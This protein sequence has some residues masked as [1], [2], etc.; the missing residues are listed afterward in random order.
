MARTINY[1]TAEEL[2][3]KI[4][5]EDR[6]AA[7]DDDGDGTPDTGMLTLVIEQACDEVDTFYTI[8]GVATPVN[9]TDNPLAKLAALH[10]A[11]ETLYTRRG[12]PAE[13]WPLHK[14]TEQ[15]RN[16][17]VKV[18]NGSL[19]VGPAN[20]TGGTGSTSDNASEGD[21]VSAEQEPAFTYPG[22]GRFV[23]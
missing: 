3:A 14:I 11:G 10:I 20:G 8:R 19:S 1:L 15:L 7:C 23:S 12:Q 17:L 21:V 16:M 22:R 2:I 6:D 13:R 5:A 4:P 9:T 18:A